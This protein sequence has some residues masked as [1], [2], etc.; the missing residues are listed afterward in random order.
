MK[1]V[2]KFLDI[3]KEFKIFAVVYSMILIIILITLIFY[4]HLN[5]KEYLNTLTQTYNNQF[6]VNFDNFKQLSENTFFGIIN[7]PNIYNNVKLAYQATPEKQLNYRNQLYKNFL[8]DYVRIQQYKFDIVHFHFPD[9][10]SFLRMYEPK[11][12]AD[13]LEKYRYS[14]VK[15]NQT[16]KPVEGFEIGK[17]MAAFRFVYP[18]TDENL[19]HIGSVETSI[20]S[21]ALEH[22]IELSYNVDMHFLLNKNLAQKKL[23]PEILKQYKQSE[24]NSEY[25]FLEFTKNE[26]VHYVNLSFY[27][28]SEKKLIQEKMQNAEEFMIMKTKNS[29][30]YTVFFKPITNVEGQKNSA[31]A[32]IY[33]KSTALELLEYNFYKML[34]IIILL[35]L[36][37]GYFLKK[38]YDDILKT[39]KKEIMISQQSKLISMGEMIGNIA[40]QWRQPLSTISTAASGNKLQKELG[41]LTDEFFYQSMDAIVEQTR[42]LSDTIEDFRNF[43]QESK[44]KKVVNIKEIIEQSLKIFGSSLNQ[45]NIQ[46]Q[47]DLE[48]VKLTTYGNEIKQVIINFLKN[49]KDAIGQNGVI[50]ITTKYFEESNSLEIEVTDSGGGIPAHIR[51]RIFEPYFTTKHQSVGTGIGL[52]MSHEIVKSSLKGEI[53][54]E[55]KSFDY[56]FK[57]YYGAA[58]KIRLFNIKEK[59]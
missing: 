31:Y 37:L 45:H 33:S 58:F 48:D 53:E 18:L 34:I 29:N 46:V 14:I 59:E 17:H 57:S 8:S 7:K 24:E 16:L 41:V 10:T 44:S 40:H 20:L 5:Q 21:Q 27:T 38:R 13:E 30:Y 43:F 22:S 50:L 3:I 19:F 2:Q 12:Y 42:Y 15:A 51:N 4:K 49:A 36:I 47:V 28:N 39:R 11:K 55:N 6:K 35:N 25:I 1:I 54:V 23:T 56:N 26:P 9:N 32:I 52:Y